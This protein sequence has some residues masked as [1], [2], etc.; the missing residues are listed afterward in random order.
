MSLVLIVLRV[1][2][3]Q[4]KEDM[5]LSRIHEMQLTIPITKANMETQQVLPAAITFTR[6]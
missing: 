5:I 2:L 4:S 3:S 6:F 1:F